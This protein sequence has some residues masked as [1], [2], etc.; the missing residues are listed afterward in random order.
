MIKGRGKKRIRVRVF[1]K[2]D[3]DFDGDGYD[4]GRDEKKEE[5]EEELCFVP[6]SPWPSPL[7]GQNIGN[8]KLQKWAC[9]CRLISTFTKFTY[10][11]PPKEKAFLT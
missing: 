1:E 10:K 6:P 7:E 8:R 2:R 11:Y 3:E 5:E 4:D 9:G